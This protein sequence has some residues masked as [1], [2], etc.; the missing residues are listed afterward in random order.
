MWPNAANVGV[1]GKIPPYFLATVGQVAWPGSEWTL[2]CANGTYG[3]D[4]SE[5]QEVVSTNC[6]E[7][8]RRRRRALEVRK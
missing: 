1:T 7:E 8:T 5:R 6:E 3:D 4:R 2:Q